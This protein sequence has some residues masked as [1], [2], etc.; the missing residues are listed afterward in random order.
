MNDQQQSES[1]SSFNP[2]RHHLHGFNPNTNA[3]GLLNPPHPAFN[4][5]TYTY[6]VDANGLAYAG[7]TPYLSTFNS[8]CLPTNLEMRDPPLHTPTSDW[9]PGGYPYST[10]VAYPS[11]SR[12][13]DASVYPW[14]ESQYMH[15]DLCNGLL[16]A[17]S[18]TGSSTA[19]LA[20]CGHVATSV[21]L[22]SPPR[23]SPSTPILLAQSIRQYM[24]SPPLSGLP[25]RPL[26]SP[27]LNS[28]PIP[29]SPLLDPVLV[30]NQQDVTLLDTLVDKCNVEKTANPEANR[31]E[32]WRQRG[33]ALYPD[34]LPLGQA[35]C[36]SADCIPG[37]CLWRLPKEEQDLYKDMVIYQSQ[38]V[39]N[40]SFFMLT[41]AFLR[42][43]PKR[44]G[45]FDWS[46]GFINTARPNQRA[47]F[48]LWFMVSHLICSRILP[49]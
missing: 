36:C 3:D 29:T 15:I 7:T 48:S 11:H 18:S 45:K 9:G 12:Q 44:G 1:E 33:Y 47:V 42:Q 22:C 4:I 16:P 20:Y 38:A 43:H 24:Q 17:G 2:L 28:I 34:D 26:S 10:P 14:H 25:P 8:A 32:A 41:K 31:M 40:T 21:P 46:D 30:F 23:P 5:N 35:P 49:C 19:H 27:V 37:G 13:P 39:R 6:N